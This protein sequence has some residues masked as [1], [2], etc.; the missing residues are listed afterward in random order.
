MSKV[1]SKDL[2][3]ACD[4]GTK[5][6][7]K[8]HTKTWIGYK[9]HIDSADG[10]VP[11]SCILTSASTH[12]SQVVIPLAAITNQR[13]TNLYDL[14]DSAYDVP[15]IREYSSSLRHIPIIDVNPRRDTLKKIEIKEESK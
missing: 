2:P 8:G 7:S 9:L 3:A 1:Q 13:T 15:Q 6:N 5:R 10:Q 11:V 4:V 12:D 14:M